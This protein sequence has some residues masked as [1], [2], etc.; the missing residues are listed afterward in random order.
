MERRELDRRELPSC[1]PWGPAQ[2]GTRYA[3]GIVF[4]H[5]AGHGGFVLDRERAQ[6]IQR[7]IPLFETFGENGPR[8]YEEDCDASVVIVVFEEAFS[9]QQVFN[10]IRSIRS[11][12]SHGEYSSDWNAVYAYVLSKPRLLARE[13]AFAATVAGQWERGSMSSG[14]FAAEYSG[15]WNVSFRRVGGEERLSKMIP[16]YPEKQFYTDEELAR[17]ETYDPAKHDRVRSAVGGAA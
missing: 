2:G 14:S 6:T 12:S 15:C 16:S 4:V 9:D 1:T 7:L 11:A 17:F 13:R 5:T 3:D 10:A 8:F